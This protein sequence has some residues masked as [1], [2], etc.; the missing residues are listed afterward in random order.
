MSN[1]EQD[2]EV[3]DL[4]VWQKQ[5]Y[6]VVQEYRQNLKMPVVQEHLKLAGISHETA[7]TA[8]L[9]WNPVAKHWSPDAWGIK[10]YKRA[11]ITLPVGLIMPGFFVN[12]SVKFIKIKGYNSTKA[13]YSC[14]P[15]SNVSPCLWCANEQLDFVLV[16]DDYLARLLFVQNFNYKV[17]TLLLHTTYQKLPQHVIDVLKRNNTVIC[18]TMNEHGANKISYQEYWKGT[19]PNNSIVKEPLLS[20][21]PTKVLLEKTIRTAWVHQNVAE[22]VLQSLGIIEVKQP[23]EQPIP[24][25]FGAS[26]PTERKAQP[27]FINQYLLDHYNG[28]FMAM[29]NE[30]KLEP[31][32]VI[33]L[34]K[35]F[36]ENAK[37]VLPKELLTK[38][39][40]K[41]YV[42]ECF[43][44]T[45]ENVKEL[46][47]KLGL[48]KNRTVRLLKGKL[49][50][51]SLESL[52]L[53]QTNYLYYYERKGYVN[54]I[55]QK[56]PRWTSGA[57]KKA[58]LTKLGISAT[59]LSEYGL[60]IYMPTLTAALIIADHYKEAPEV[61]FDTYGD[62]YKVE[63][64]YAF[65]Q[66]NDGKM[67]VVFQR[68]TETKQPEIKKET[69]D[70]QT[71]NLPTRTKVVVQNCNCCK[72]G[73]LY[74]AK[75]PEDFN[76]V[77]LCFK[78]MRAENVETAEKTCCQFFEPK[79]K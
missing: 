77:C 45:C 69:I 49:R 34:L 63:T 31:A 50:R 71:N 7:H 44:D 43:L 74:I 55:N 70:M 78:D 66:Y 41:P 29:R 37:R 20:S 65:V 53:A 76:D 39:Q 5:A 22:T 40:T 18:L 14:V 38:Y 2:Y 62:L 28:S 51:N 24:E 64:P 9:G 35:G 21:A 12:G 36:A 13:N 57:H 6:A 79:I 10:K 75:H 3:A 4:D 68:P 19:F 26:Q 59:M 25:W 52:G 33:A 17:P 11:Y 58:L 47:K 8:G 73:V 48:N 16:T 61:L 15:G 30:L 54:H 42:N 56:F 32:N 23:E 60:G 67:V 46:S 27:E 1:D 72:Y